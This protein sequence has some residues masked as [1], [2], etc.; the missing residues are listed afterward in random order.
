[1]AGQ[2]LTECPVPEESLASEVGSPQMVRT[3]SKAAATTAAA[4]NSVKQI[5]ATVR[6]VIRSVRTVSLTGYRVTNVVKPIPRILILVGLAGLIIGVAAAIQQATILGVTGM[7]IA[8]TGAYL[9]VFGAWQTNKYVLS[10]VVS[11]TVLGATA[12]L[13]LPAV[14]RG[15]FGT[16]ATDN[17]WLGRQMDWIGSTW[18]HPF[19]VLGAILLPFII[20]TVMPRLFGRKTLVTGPR[21]SGR[22]AV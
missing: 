19:I 18:W 4:L 16:S 22:R 2:L 12:S 5:P 14:R 3:V 15:L 8:A 11:V 21:P 10:A 13:A 6:P 9:I 20:I 1:M 17:G 7:I